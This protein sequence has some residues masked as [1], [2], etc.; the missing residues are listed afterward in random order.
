MSRRF[1]LSIALLLL[2]VATPALAQRRA[3]LLDLRVGGAI[4]T[5]DIADE[6][7]AG[8]A[9][10]AGLGLPLGPRLVLLVDGDYARHGIDGAA[11][12]HIA[13]FHAM[14]KLG[15]R[16]GRPDARVQ[17]TPNLGAGVL[18]FNPG[19]TALL[20]A[21]DTNTYFAINAGAR[22]TVNLG[23]RFD[24]LFSPQGDIAFIPEEDRGPDGASTAWVWPVTAGLR[25]KF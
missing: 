13:V 4:P 9:V 20:D 22:I 18:A 1:T 12:G 7:G 15:L 8:L 21:L 16:L 3:P 17:V 11:A 10:G 2:G 25:I 14:G 19:G 23:P 5:F 24:L 6:V